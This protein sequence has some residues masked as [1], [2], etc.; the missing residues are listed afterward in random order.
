MPPCYDSDLTI[1]L[2]RDVMN[3]VLGGGYKITVVSL[4]RECTLI[5]DC[6]AP[7]VRISLAGEKP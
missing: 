4:Q 2:G 1:P 6:T 7:L 5:A 3:K